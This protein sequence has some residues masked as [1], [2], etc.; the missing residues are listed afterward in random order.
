MPMPLTAACLMMEELS[1]EYLP[2]GTI[3]TGSLVLAIDLPCDPK[4]VAIAKRIRSD[5]EWFARLRVIIFKAQNTCECRSR[6]TNP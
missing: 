3:E 5:S 2:L 6:A 1:D 4:G